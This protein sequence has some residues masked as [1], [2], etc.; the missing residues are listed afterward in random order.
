MKSLWLEGGNFD[1]SPYRK[2]HLA[3]NQGGTIFSSV[4]LS[5]IVKVRNKSNRTLDIFLNDSVK[6]SYFEHVFVNS[7]IHENIMT[8]TLL[9][10]STNHSPSYLVL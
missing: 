4:L 6:E 2:G 10:I 1:A 5:C 9:Y 8:V 3:G 7:Y